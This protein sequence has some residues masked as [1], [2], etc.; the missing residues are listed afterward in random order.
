MSILDRS[1]GLIMA[2]CSPGTRVR[3]Q[4]IP[5]SVTED[6]QKNADYR[7]AGARGRMMWRFASFAVSRTQQSKYSEFMFKNSVFNGY[8]A[9]SAGHGIHHKALS[10]GRCRPG[11]AGWERAACAAGLLSRAV[12]ARWAVAVRRGLLSGPDHPGGEGCCL[13]APLHAQLGQQRGYVVLGR[14][15]GQEH[16][17]G[18]LPV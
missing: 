16:L 14:L 13:G 11:A 18:D 17:L 5:G 2:T 7:T 6:R 3:V 12:A 8:R 1:A 10:G 4:E 15:L 9:I